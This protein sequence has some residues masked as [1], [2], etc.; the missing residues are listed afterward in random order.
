M[1]MKLAIALTTLLSSAFAAVYINNPVAG[2]VWPHDGSPVTISW[3][4][5]DN[6]V[7]TGT[8][9]VQLMEGDDANLLPIITIASGVAASQGKVT[10]TPPSS[11]VGSSNYAVRVTSSV[12]G[13]HYSHSFTAGNPAN[14]GS[15][16]AIVS[17][18]AA[19]SSKES[20][21]AASTSKSAT[22]KATSKASATE[23]DSSE[24]QSDLSSDAEESSSDKTNK[25]NKPSKTSSKEESSEEEDAS[26]H[27]HSSS[28]GAGR[29]Q[30]AFG[31]LGAA[32]AVAVAMF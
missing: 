21:S 19:S 24:E 28:S 14:T 20:S 11:L 8:V 22:T 25:D 7:L 12:D 26:S 29:T 4:S 32:A 18:T 16:S 23:T 31:V 1:Q 5:D 2:T 30:L 13:P 15:A 27:D 9:I 3:V 10:F 6:T 17:S